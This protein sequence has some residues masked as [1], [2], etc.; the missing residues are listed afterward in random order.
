MLRERDPGITCRASPEVSQ[1]RRTGASLTAVNGARCCAT[2]SPHL[3]AGSL[4]RLE[5]LQGSPDLPCH[6]VVKVRV[7]SRPPASQLDAQVAPDACVGGARP[8]SRSAS[9]AGPQWAGCPP[10]APRRDHSDATTLQ[11]ETPGSPDPPASEGMGGF[12]PGQMGLHPR[13]WAGPEGGRRWADCEGAGGRERAQ[14]PTRAMAYRY[15]LSAS[16][17]SILSAHMG[18]GRK[19]AMQIPHHLPESSHGDTIAAE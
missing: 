12:D 17:L 3:G 9:G 19:Q 4:Q 13:P 10:S 11:D 5:P 6:G 2:K 14:E 18:A 7:P 1:C 8:R 16:G 15:A